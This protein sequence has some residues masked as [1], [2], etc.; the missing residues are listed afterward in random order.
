[1]VTYGRCQRSPK[2]ILDLHRFYPMTQ[3]KEDRWLSLGRACR[4]LGV[5]E[6]TLRQ[7]AND[8]RIRT[9]RTV[10]GHRRF[11][12]D[13]V[14]ALLE[15]PPRGNE[16]ATAEASTKSA[17]DR[18]RRRI[19]RRKGQPEQWMEHFDEE[20]K[21]R[22]RMLGRRLVSLATEYRTQK[23][24]RGELSEEARYLGL[25]YGR[26][27]ASREVRL[28]DAISAFIF[29]RNSL[30]DSMRQTS[31]GDAREWAESRS[32]VMALEDIVLLG[33]TEAYERA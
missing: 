31:G 13:E 1:M 16:E 6:S 9:F 26:E 19:Q 32:D 2:I 10:G 15:A 28:G 22:M 4:I 11:P 25:D 30:H 33:L 12:R 17:L 7:W 23:R 14:Y 27:L 18:M 21:A 3:T 20:G 29:F 5:N 8:G 24:R